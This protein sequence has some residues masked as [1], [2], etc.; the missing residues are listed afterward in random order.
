MGR[1]VEYSKHAPIRR[2]PDRGQL[3]LIAAKDRIFKTLRPNQGTVSGAP[4]RYGLAV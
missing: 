2:G 4:D 3:R 1:L